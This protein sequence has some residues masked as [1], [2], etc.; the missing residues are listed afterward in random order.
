MNQMNITLR[1]G[2]YT[3]QGRNHDV[4]E[5][6]LRFEQNGTVKGDGVDDVGREFIG[7]RFANLCSWINDIYIDISYIILLIYLFY[8]IYLCVIIGE[9][10]GID[11]QSESVVH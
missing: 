2:Y 3:Y 6:H 4:C 7:V 8:S 10:I 9:Y 1:R 11:I 5:F